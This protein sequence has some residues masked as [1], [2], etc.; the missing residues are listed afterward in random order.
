M[1]TI[2]EKL[3]G[4]SEQISFD[5]LPQEVVH[6]AKMTILDTLGCAL[7][8]FASDPAKI[9]RGVVRHLGG[10]PQATILGTTERTSVLGATWANGT[11]I[12]YLDYNDCGGGGHN[13]DSIPGILA[14]S[15]RE[16]VSG[17]DF[18]TSVGGH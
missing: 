6:K 11:A 7:G 8:G 9:M 4:L 12:R 18:L 14:V 10:H 2:V 17:R 16:N 3:A 13:S 5:S 15:E 1:T